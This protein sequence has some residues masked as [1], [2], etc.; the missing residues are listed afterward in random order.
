MFNE[1]DRLQADHSN[2]QSHYP[3]NSI[4]KFKKMTKDPRKLPSNIDKWRFPGV[5]MG[6]FDIAQ[7]FNLRFF[8]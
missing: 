1:E 2:P 7:L 4:S 3:F 6:Y 8:P 5:Q